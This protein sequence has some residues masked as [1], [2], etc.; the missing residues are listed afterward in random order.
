MG[1]IGCRR[2]C[3]SAAPRVVESGGGAWWTCDGAVIGMY[4]LQGPMKG[5]SAISR[6]GIED[7]GLRASEPEAA[8]ARTW[9][10]TGS[11]RR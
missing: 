1:A 7:D 5:Y 10:A 4:G 2:A 11:G 6:A 8:A 9:I 3:A